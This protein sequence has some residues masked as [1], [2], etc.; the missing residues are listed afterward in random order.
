[1]LA[2]HAIRAPGGQRVV[3]ALVR[4]PDGLLRNQRNPRAVKA[5]QIAHPV[6]RGSRH[7]PGVATVAQHMAEAVVVLKHKCRLRAQLIY[8][9]VPVDLVGKIDVEVGDDRLPLVRQIRWRGEIG[10]LDILQVAHERLLW[11]ASR[12]RIPLD[13]ALIDH[14]RKGEARMRSRL[15]HH[16]FGRRI[17]VVILAVPIDHHAIDSACDH[18]VDLEMDL[19]RI[20]GRVTDVHVVR[21]SK[22][23]H[24]MGKDLGRSALIQQRMNVHLADIAGR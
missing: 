19:V 11:R 7:H 22:P 10:L 15:R 20:V 8:S 4:G 12:A 3:E 24:Q 5:R 13:G 9:R 6:V 23:Q 1:M 2:H 17:D 18:V 16:Q 14:H 21:W